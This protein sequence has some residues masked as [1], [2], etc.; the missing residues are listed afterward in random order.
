M[1][2]G[3]LSPEGSH[4]S[5]IVDLVTEV[6]EDGIAEKHVC[7]TVRWMLKHSLQSFDLISL[8]GEAFTLFSLVGRA[9]CL[10]W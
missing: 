7:S 1:Y 9:Y 3:R 5:T 6:D 4:R 10:K 8:D 2:G